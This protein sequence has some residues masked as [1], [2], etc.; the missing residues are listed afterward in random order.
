MNM[1]RVF[2][3]A[4]PVWP[5]GLG[6]L[7]M[8]VIGLLS[9]L[10]D[11]QHR[12][13]HESSRQL[14][15]LRQARIELT[16]GFLQ[17]SL[18]GKPEAPFN[19][20]DG[21]ALLRQSIDTFVR[22]LTS[23]HMQGG[24]EAENFR[25]SVEAFRQRLNDWRNTPTPEGRALVALRI[26]FADLERSTHRL[27][28][29]GHRHLATLIA[30][31]DRVYA[32]SLAGSLL[33]L[34]LIVG[35]VLY[36][37]RRER[38]AAAEQARLERA[39]GDS[40]ARFARLFQEAPLP[41]CL[42]D[43]N[44]ALR[45]RNR[46]FD[47]TFG[48]DH[49]EL[50]NL[51]DWW[52]LAY[53]DTAYR[54]LMQDMWRAAVTEAARSGTDIAPTECRVTCKD[55]HERVMLISGIPL[56]ED[57]L[58]T[59]FDISE[60]KQAEQ[61]QAHALA[62]QKAARR[63]TERTAAA[64]QESQERLQLL[65][66]HAPA[67]LA[68]FNRDMRYLAV[69]Q[70]WLDDYGL[71]ERDILGHSHYDIFPEIPEAW[72]A[73]HQRGMAGEIVMA[74]EDRFDRADG[75]TQWLRWEVRPWHSAG[76]GIG[77]IVIFSEDI[78]RLMAARHEILELNA[79]LERRVVERTAELSA[80]NRELDAFAY[81]VS[82]DLRTP[83]RAMSGFAQALEEDYG[84]R[85]DGEA[86]NHLA[87]IGLASRR[88]DDLI[89]GILTLSRSTRGELRRDATDLSALARRCL[90]EL[91]HQEPQRR[92]EW[93]VQ[94]G[95]TATGDARML[96]VVVTNLIG[97]AWKYSAG[98]NPA[99]I[100]CCAEARD[101]QPWFCVADDGAGFDPAQ[102]ARLF[103]P[104]QRLHRQD[105]FPGLGIGLATVARIVHRHGG[106][107]EARGEV[108]KGATFCFTLAGGNAAEIPAPTP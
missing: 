33:V 40:E 32:W 18:A 14:A 97:N 12:A 38:L 77:G 28:A 19:R 7:G 93:T 24:P 57:F 95:L 54:N 31:N 62:E 23:L 27:D 74:D 42:V 47:Q 100:R 56:G 9:W 71:G 16:Q 26:A 87:Q 64:L 4:S 67:A 102:A 80:A 101:G 45:T 39:R 2:M 86:K 103:Q 13:M 107:I 52:P 70:R 73:V 46:R 25:R 79:G 99:H 11:T 22:T 20:D 29:Q 49:D 17:I 85:L 106:E 90:E 82:H 84:E 35:I 6:L 58:A 1:P 10:H 59:F 81:A 69:S 98:R 44:G 89:E 65:I 92:V 34:G 37:A 8:V 63:E 83:L 50:R 78:T 43:S 60:R 68:M 75:S 66:D 105:E 61:A 91:A 108:G 94:P 88:M 3:P 53:P 72:R 48:Y 104:F 51:D 41:L 5:A 55:G 96:E 36:S 21:Q 30:N 15:E 76:S